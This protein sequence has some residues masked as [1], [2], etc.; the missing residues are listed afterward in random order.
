MDVDSIRRYNYN[1]RYKANKTNKNTTKNISF[2]MDFIPPNMMNVQEEL[3][4]AKGFLPTLKS[5]FVELGK[6]LSEQNENSNQNSE[7]C[8]VTK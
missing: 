6:K 1:S 4:T 3:T 2:K 5:F 8:P 7:Q